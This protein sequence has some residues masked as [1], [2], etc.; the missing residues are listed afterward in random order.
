MYNWKLF[1][2]IILGIVIAVAVALITVGIA[3]GVNGLT[4][5]QQITEWFGEAA[6]VVEQVTET[7]AETPMA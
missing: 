1:L 7:V 2:G 4:F 5:G 6:P 3:C